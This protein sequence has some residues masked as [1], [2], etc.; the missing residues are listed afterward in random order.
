MLHKGAKAYYFGRILHDYSDTVAIEILKQLVP[1]MAPDSIVLISDFVLP[2]RI[3]PEDI[4]AAAAGIL[5]LTMAGKERSV[6]EI[7]A[8]IEAA[9]LQMIGKSFLESISQFEDYTSSTTIDLVSDILTFP[10]SV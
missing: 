10:R 4:E 7:R 2:D 1:A 3:T 9:G 8:I 5:I 6:S